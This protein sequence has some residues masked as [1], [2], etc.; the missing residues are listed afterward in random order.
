MAVEAF[1]N[2]PIKDDRDHREHC[3]LCT[4]SA[5]N[6]FCWF[7]PE[8]GISSTDRCLLRTPRTPPVGT[9][10]LITSSNWLD[11]P[12]FPEAK[13]LPTFSN[14]PATRGLWDNSRLDKSHFW[15]PFGVEMLLAPS[16]N[17]WKLV[18]MTRV[19]TGELETRTDDLLGAI[20]I[21]GIFDP[22]DVLELKK[23]ASFRSSLDSDSPC[24]K[25]FRRVP[26]PSIWKWLYWTRWFTLFRLITGRPPPFSCLL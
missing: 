20:G 7:F 12:A 15:R 6:W 24:L 19:R 25:E 18:D 1:C 22:W 23:Y 3:F 26:R 14:V 4:R 9:D 11:N 10:G 8:V 2:F 16:L 21:S 5:H 17:G 13:Q